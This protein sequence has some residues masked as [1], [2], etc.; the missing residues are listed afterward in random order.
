MYV[1]EFLYQPESYMELL[2]TGTVKENKIFIFAAHVF[3]FC[4]NIKHADISE[5]NCYDS[6]NY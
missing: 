5:G 3:I 4:I 6:K 2:H 1:C